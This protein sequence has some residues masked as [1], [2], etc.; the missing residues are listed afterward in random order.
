MNSISRDLAAGAAGDSE[1]QIV[2]SMG[3]DAVL[4]AEI[5]EAVKGTE[6]SLRLEV[7]KDIVWTINGQTVSEIVGDI[8]FGVIR[9][10]DTIPAKLIEETAAGQ[11]YVPLS[12]AHE[13]SFGMTAVLSMRLGADRI[14]KYANLFYYNPEKS[15]MEFVDSSLVAENGWAELTYEHASDYLLVM[16]DKSM[17][18]DAAID[19][20]V[21]EA[22]ENAVAEPQQQ[23]G[24]GWIWILIVI[25]LAASGGMAVYFRKKK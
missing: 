18:P 14:G 3:E 20:T 12:L 4:P 25:V 15:S 11:E 2:I 19:E 5:L 17:E 24:S 10:A 7:E 8:D 6:L 23:K 1:K 9:S 22:S 16:S 13:G 21:Q